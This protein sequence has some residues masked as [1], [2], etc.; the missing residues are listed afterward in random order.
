[1]ERLTKT[2]KV[3][4]EWATKVDFLAPRANIA[5]AM[6]QNNKTKKRISD[7]S[8]EFLTWLQVERRFAKSSI[9]SYR[10]RL[11]CFVRDVGDIE[12]DRFTMEDIFKLKQILHSRNN[13]ETFIG[14]CL[15]VC[16][17]LL[18][19]YREHYSVQFQ[20]NPDLILGSLINWFA[21]SYGASDPSKFVTGTSES[22]DEY[23]ER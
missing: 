6:L 22:V 16:K 8:E 11:K 7:V 15:A 17:G 14:V 12:L 1:M 2:G 21:E 19:Y 18:K 9:V 23:T 4:N 5:S 20:I 10:S 3:G 13:S